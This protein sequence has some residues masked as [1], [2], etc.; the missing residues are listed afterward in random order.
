MFA[1]KT[2]VAV[3]AAVAGVVSAAPSGASPSAV[4][5]P[6]ATPYLTTFYLGNDAISNGS[7]CVV[8]VDSYTG[9]DGIVVLSGS[10]NC[11]D[12]QGTVSQ[13]LCGSS[14]ITADFQGGDRGTHLSYYDENNALV[15]YC[16]LPSNPGNSAQC[17]TT[18]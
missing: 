11:S 4:P 7:G 9:C 16:T 3:L 14:S 6:S 1:S 13:P 15:A 10:Q 5:T 12:I 2:I 18:D 8:E 17:A